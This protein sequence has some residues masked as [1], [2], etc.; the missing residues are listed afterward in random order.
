[1]GLRK[2]TT[3]ISKQTF[4]SLCAL[5]AGQ[6]QQKARQLSDLQGLRERLAHEVTHRVRHLQKSQGASVPTVR[7]PRRTHASPTE[8]KS[9]KPRNTTG[10][11]SSTQV[12]SQAPLPAPR[13]TVSL[14]A[15]RARPQRNSTP[16][17]SSEE[18]SV[19]DSAYIT[20]PRSKST[21]SVRVV[22]SGPRQNQTVDANED[23]S[24][25]EPSEGSASPSSKRSPRAQGSVVQSL[26]RSLERQLSAPMTKPVGGTR[27]LPPATAASHKPS[28]VVQLSDEDSDLE[29]SSIEEISPQAAGGRTPGVRGSADSAGSPGTSVW[30]SSASR[31]GGW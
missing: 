3:G 27:V 29:L 30:S 20:S 1:M 8:Q 19:G 16:P 28:A 31:G 5:V 15:P 25:T 24:D 13:S 6:R 11:A 17:F 2:G 23:W 22:Q 18:D 26:T 7:T 21:L 12:Q 9:P 10:K 4:K 14:R